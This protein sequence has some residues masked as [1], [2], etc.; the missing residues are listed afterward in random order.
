MPVL[1]LNYKVSTYFP[2]ISSSWVSEFFTE[3]YIFYL[4]SQFWLKKLGKYDLLI[5]IS[6]FVILHIHFILSLFLYSPMVSSIYLLFLQNYFKWTHVVVLRCSCNPYIVELQTEQ[7]E[8]HEPAA[9]TVSGASRAALPWSIPPE[10][11]SSPRQNNPTP[12]PETWRRNMAVTETSCPLIGW[13]QSDVWT[14]RE[15]NSSIGTGDS[16]RADVALKVTIIVV[17]LVISGV[18]IVK[19][20]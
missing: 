5:S 8:L 3:V 2:K 10:W 1:N 20:C 19:Q 7:I 4:P 14:D 9:L 12:T 15:V 11:R 16:I 13:W 17:I 6:L 18:C